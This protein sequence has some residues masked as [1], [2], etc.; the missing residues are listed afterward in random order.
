MAWLSRN[1]DLP[2]IETSSEPQP[3]TE[4]G[5][6]Y[7]QSGDLQVRFMEA[8]EKLVR[9]KMQIRT[10]EREVYAM[11]RK[12]RRRRALHGLA[13]GGV[14]TAVATL[15]ACIVHELID[16]PV[17]GWFV[18]LVGFGF[19]FGALFG[20]RWDTVD[21]DFPEAPPPRGVI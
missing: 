5:G 21:D 10:L 13:F 16:E 9:A 2:S 11:R 7:R 20:M 8:E 1:A 12:A 4:A 18:W 14:G 15:V 6:A 3:L 19:V 17:P